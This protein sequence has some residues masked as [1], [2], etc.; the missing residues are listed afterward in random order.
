MADTEIT[1]ESLQEDPDF[2]DVAFHSMRAMGYNPDPGDPQGI[3]DQF[4]ENKRYFDVNL[5][6]TLSQGNKIVD[7]PDG[8]KQLYK[9][10]LDKV[11]KMPDF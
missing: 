7:L 3:L 4:L 11:N 9:H 2:L 5:V 6:S 1:Y 10:A 8:Y